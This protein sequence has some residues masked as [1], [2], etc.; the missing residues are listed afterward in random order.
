MLTT[1]KTNNCLLA[2]ISPSY[3]HCLLTM[4]FL[5][6]FK[7]KHLKRARSVIVGMVKKKKQ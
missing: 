4:H 1:V 3:F 5:E 2:N 7:K 6:N